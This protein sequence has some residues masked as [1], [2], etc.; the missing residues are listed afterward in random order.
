MRRSLAALTLAVLALLAPDTAGQDY[1]KHLE[2]FDLFNACRPMGLVIEHLHDHAAAIGLTR[3]ALQ[4]AA[5]SRLRAA[6]LYSDDSANAGFTYLYVQVSVAGQAHAISVRYNKRLTDEF[7]IS[8]WAVTWQ[9]GSTGTHSGQAGFIV[10]SLSRHL[11]KFLAAYLRVN[12]A[13]C[14]AR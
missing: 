6:R 12:E 13:A 5:E 2:R 7:G 4:A 10:S 11:D 14:E 8:G 3:E 9:S 1:P